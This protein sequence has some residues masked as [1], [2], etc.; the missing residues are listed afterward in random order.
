MY[1]KYLLATERNSPLSTC[2]IPLFLRQGGIIG[3]ILKQKLEI[4]DFIVQTNA[5][6]GMHGADGAQVLGVLAEPTEVHSVQEPDLQI[7]LRE[8]GVP[9]Y[10]VQ[11]VLVVQFRVHRPRVVPELVEPYGSV[12]RLHVVE[13]SVRHVLQVERVPMEEVTCYLEI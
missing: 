3:P 2:G 11:H 7:H 5:T 4:I 12:V 13:P 8:E 9:F 6:I 1:S 10:P